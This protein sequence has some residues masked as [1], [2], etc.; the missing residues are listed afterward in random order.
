MT[1]EDLEAQGGE[2]RDHEL[3]RLLTSWQMGSDQNPRPQTAA[4]GWNLES[5]GKI[6][7]LF[8]VV[9]DSRELSFFLAVPHG[10]WVLSP[11]PKV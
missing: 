10:T 5:E 3:H 8:R 7:F 6:S 1:R 2:P 4:Q 9:V 11:P